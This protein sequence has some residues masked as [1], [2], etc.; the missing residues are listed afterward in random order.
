VRSS[1]HTRCPPFRAF[2]NK[3]LDYYF[4][5]PV[6]VADDARWDDPDAPFLRIKAGYNPVN[7]GHLDLG[8]FSS[9]PGVTGPRHGRTYNLDGYWESRRGGRR[10]SYYRLNSASHNVP[11]LG[12]ASQDPMAKSSFTKTEINRAQP[13]AVVNLTEAYQGFAGS[14]VRGVTMIEGR[15]AVLIQDELQ[16]KKPSDAVWGLTTD[17]EIDVKQGTVVVLKLKGKELTARLLSPKNAVFTVESAEQQPPQAKNTGVR[18]LLVKLSQASGDICIAVLF[19]PAW[20]DGKVVEAA[21]I[22]PL[23]SW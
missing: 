16:M 12:G 4:R 21:E 2:R 1:G 17:A 11:M 13:V 23:A 20:H 19:S 22:K 6:E 3:Q 8:N 7:H 5:G 18:R 9:T 10:W 15:R 14:A